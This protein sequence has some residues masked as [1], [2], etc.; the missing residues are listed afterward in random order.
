MWSLCILKTQLCVTFYDRQ[1]DTLME[2]IILNNYRDRLTKIIFLK[3]IVARRT[4]LNVVVRDISL[5]SR[6]KLITMTRFQLQ[7]DIC[8]NKARALIII[9]LLLLKYCSLILQQTQPPSFVMPLGVYNKHKQVLEEDEWRRSH[10]NV[11]VLVA[12]IIYETKIPQ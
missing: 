10:K 7:P 5:L 1:K 3:L 8:K 2:Q 6:R 11:C 9:S 12:F 4:L